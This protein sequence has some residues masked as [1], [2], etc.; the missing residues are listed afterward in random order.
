MTAVAG[1]PPETLPDDRRARRNAIVLAFAQALAGSNN[2]IMVGTASI[3]GAMLAP[4]RALA[5]LPVSIYVL[6]LW[7]GTLPVGALTRRYGRRTAFQIGTLCGVATGILCFFAV[8]SN[9]FLLFNIGAFITGLY[10]SAQQAY[11]FAAADTASE[12]FRPKAISW[13]LTGGVGAAIIAPQL[14]IFTKDSWPPYLFATTYLAQ[15]LLAVLAACV[16]HFIDIP[17]PA[18]RSGMRAGRPLR[19]IIRQPR[20]IT[21]VACGVTSYAMMNMVMTS[22][23][24]A[25]IMCNHT[26]D[27]A[28]LGI[29]WHVLGMFVPSFFTGG[30]IARFGTERMV[31]AGL[32][33]LATSA[34]ISI[35]GISLGHFW[36]GLAV[37]GIGWNFGFIGA[38]AMVT[39][40]CR[41]EERHTVQPLNDFLMFG[42][43]S[44]GSFLSGAVLATNG[45]M[46]VNEIVLPIVLATAML[47]AWFMLRGR[48]LHAA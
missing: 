2:I 36:V 18:A 25:M 12:A 41:P 22:A 10:A 5:T 3:V 14:I 15:A 48:W 34:A 23:P 13:V 33:L 19:E 27:D 31:A 32:A 20:L 17:R 21:A 46:M 29:Q 4:N 47:L 7:M 1:A 44:V 8:L 40:C 26:T 28:A 43:M 24:L 45:W 42:T 6:G 39:Q 37:L 38:T 9:S 16:L 11:R 30:L 35:S